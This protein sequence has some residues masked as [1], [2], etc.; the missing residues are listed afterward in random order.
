M[1]MSDR[2]TPSVT[3]RRQ[4]LSMMAAGTFL[5]AGGGLVSSC[6]RDGSASGEV[7]LKTT[8]GWPYGPMP[9]AK[10]QQGNAGT[11]AYAEVLGEWMD[12]N[13]GVTIKDTKLD[14]WNQQTLS[15]AITGGTAPSMF[16]GDVLGGWNRQAVR[17]AMAQGLSAD[18]TEH[19]KT[20]DIEGKLAT[21]VKP[22]W[23]KW[24][25]DGKFYAAPWIYNV[26]T[27]LHYR[28]DLI[29]QL[30]LK[31]PTP[32]WTWDDVR[33]LARG[34]TQG[35]RKGIVLQGWGLNQRLSADG[36]DFH[37]KLPAPGTNWNW[38]YDYSSQADRWVPLIQAMRDMVFKDKSV[39]ADVSMGDGDTLAA[40][41]RGDAAIHNNTVIF[42]SNAPGSDNAPADL[43][44]RLNKPIEEV[45][46]WMTQPIGLDGRNATTQGQVD[47]LGFSPD[48]G[49]T[50]LD[51]AISLHAYMQGPGWIRQHTVTYE[52][53]K[54]PK[55]VFDGANIM[56]LFAGVVDEVPS[57][58]DEAWG[59]P[60]MEQVRRAAAT[61]L[62]P[63]ESFYFPAELSPGPTET[64]RDDMSSRWANERGDLDLRE[65][66]AKL[67]TTL[68]QQA[69]SFSSSTSDPDFVRAARAYFEA[70]DA[71]WRENA[72]EYHQNVFRSWYENSVLPA[73]K[74]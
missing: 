73:L 24:A 26:G 50:A 42:F 12:K 23:Q 3:T 63:N 19:L 33:E 57:S 16:P 56:P 69:E 45:A 44:K 71:Y 29:R 7:V 14:V 32:E 48:L 51:K 37:A 64:A 70:H 20:H 27:G 21:Y 5:A 8:D 9:T 62:V 17:S 40:F 43:A 67:E 39:L 52:T 30:G 54:D 34:L 22:I 6:S 65:D 46:G 74:G 66:L 1:T 55:R 10:E 11:K 15:T 18:V 4:L 35:K 58:P 41:V 38:R 60:F 59:K 68:N 28:V 25:V 72:P 61:P 47:L 2:G 49:D 36:M 13:P 53:T 31:E